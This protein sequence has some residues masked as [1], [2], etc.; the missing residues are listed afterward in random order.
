MR[1]NSRGFTLVELLVVIAIIGILVGLLLPAVQA[2]REAARRMSCS[3]NI[4][5][6]ALAAHNFESAYKRFPPSN[7]GYWEDAAN[8]AFDGGSVGISISESPGFG[9]LVFLMPFMEQGN[10]YNQLLKS[11]GPNDHA[12]SSA[13]VGSFKG[14]DGQPWWYIDNDWELGQLTVP[15]YLCPSDTQAQND[16]LLFWLHNG[17]CESVGGIWFGAA[18]SQAH[19]NTNYMGV[20]GAMSAIRFDVGGTTPCPPHSNPERVDLN[21]D[22]VADVSN[23][24]PLRGIF[25]NARK[26]VKM[27]DVSDGTSNTLLFGESTHGDDLGFA[28]ISANWKP[29]GLMG[30][31]AHHTPKGASAWASFNSFHTGGFQ[32]ALADGSV[33]FFSQNIPIGEL[34]KLG[35]M[36]DG[37]VISAID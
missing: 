4:K 34:R 16:G 28:W 29:V 36:Q 3:N 31:P 13:R 20:G 22:G 6:I 14:A 33:R 5:Q 23:Y 24:Y 7:N 26:P 32:F 12:N 35:A 9:T 37:F 10:L 25:G 30:S 18:D 15:N 11:R 17:T 8:A 27:G 1:K 21:G 2:A 19:G